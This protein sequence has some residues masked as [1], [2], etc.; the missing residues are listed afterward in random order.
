V[1]RR[2][3]HVGKNSLPFCAE[4]KIRWS[5]TP[6]SPLYIPVVPRGLFRLDILGYSERQ[7]A[8]FACSDCKQSGTKFVFPNVSLLS[9][10]YSP[11]LRLAA[12][13]TSALKFS[14]YLTVLVF[15]NSISIPSRN[16]CIH[17]SYCLEIIGSDLE[18]N[19]SYQILQ[20]LYVQ[21]FIY[22]ILF[23]YLLLHSSFMYRRLE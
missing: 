22:L 6:T 18:R 11:V 23:T 7:D 10:L 21:I 19:E 12:N 4:V 2:P 5:Y 20:H 13:C 9:F 3:V 15:K 17:L 8:N 16:R 1:L 14:S